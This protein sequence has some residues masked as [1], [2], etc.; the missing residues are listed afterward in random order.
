[1][2]GLVVGNILVHA[3]VDDVSNDN[4]LNVLEQDKRP[5]HDDG[6]RETIAHI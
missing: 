6:N 1:M 2:Y 4:S 3:G 5:H